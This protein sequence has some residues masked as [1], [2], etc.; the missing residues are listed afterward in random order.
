MNYSF[1]VIRSN[2]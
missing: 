2:C 1:H